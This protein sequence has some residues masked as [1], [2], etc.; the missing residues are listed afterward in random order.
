MS[1]ILEVHIVLTVATGR[2]LLIGAYLLGLG[3]SEA[4]TSYVRCQESV[5]TLARV[6]LQP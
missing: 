1:F 6:L 5:V 2:A 3:N 4:L